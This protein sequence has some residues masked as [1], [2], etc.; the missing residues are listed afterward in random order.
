[1]M[2]SES[3]HTTL[4]MSWHTQFS[5]TSDF[6]S[7][8]RSANS[9]SRF[10]KLWQFPGV[11]YGL[12]SAR[13]DSLWDRGKAAMK[14]FLDVTRLTASLMGGFPS[15]IDRVEHAYVASLLRGDRCADVVPVITTPWFTGALSQQQL[16]DILA[17][18]E[19]S[20]RLAVPAAHDPTCRD[21][22][23]H[24]REP[25]SFSPGSGKR[26]SG[27]QPNP[28]LRGVIR[29][30]L[31]AIAGS[32]IRLQRRIQRLPVGRCV[33]LNTSHNQL[34]RP[35]RLSWVERAGVRPVFF[36]HDTIPIDYP[37]F[38][39]SGRSQRHSRRLQTASKLAA[40]IIVN[41]QST[42]QSLTN[43]FVR[44]GLRPPLIEA[45]P[46]GVASA[47]V[48]AGTGVRAK[49]SVSSDVRHPYFVT[50]STIEPRKNLLFLFTV[51]RELVR[52]HGA[53]TPRLV[54][55]GR[56]GWENENVVNVLERSTELTPFLV[57][58]SG[59][60]DASVAE[61]MTGA[62]ALLQPSSVEGFGLP[63]IEAMAAGVPVVASD[64]AA[65]REVVGHRSIL[66]DPIDG[67]RW[68]Q[69]IEDLAAVDSS[70]RRSALAAIAGY[71]PRD[72]TEHVDSA[73]KLL[74]RL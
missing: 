17:A 35:E 53:Q 6:E 38:V 65:H 10:L 12:L 30:P 60:G 68:C 3:T 8:S 67:I 51:W 46:L 54:V 52:R 28:W 73:L 19:I 58:A 23:R 1:M 16:R 59:L 18:V 21:L 20:W 36:I 45:L 11:D 74:E 32:A 42:R 47:F 43:H 13:C 29:L 2:K 25:V 55:V 41:S 33:Y 27:L 69:V 14:I 62:L 15:G 49:R 44:A 26:F 57:E 48:S 4:D 71:V 37:E 66:I 39:R 7:F 64:I 31:R 72:W 63:L 9:N 34:D 40:L 61:L 24:L 22:V 50:V 5:Q 70:L 56:R